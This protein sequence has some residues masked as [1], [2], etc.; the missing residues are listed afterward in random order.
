M[1]KLNFCRNVTL[2]VIKVRLG[3]SV[4][5]LQN[6]PYFL[7]ESS[8]ITRETAGK[9]EFLELQI[10]VF[11]KSVQTICRTRVVEPDETASD[12]HGLPTVS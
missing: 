6:R 8:N 9:T 3:D 4:K 2:H 1:L 10:K 11:L 5:K 12:L 7:K